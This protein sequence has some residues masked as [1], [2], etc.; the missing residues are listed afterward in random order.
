MVHI[1]FRYKNRKLYHQ[2]QSKCINF[3]D[4]QKYILNGDEVIVLD[5]G[6]GKNITAKILGSLISEIQKQNTV[7][8]TNDLHRRIVEM[9]SSSSLKMKPHESKKEILDQLS[10]APIEIEE[11]KN[12]E[13]ELVIELARLKKERVGHRGTEICCSNGMEFSSVTAAAKWAKVEW[14]EIKDC[15]VGHRFSCNDLRYWE[16]DTKGPVFLE[17]DDVEIHCSNGM[18]FQTM[19]AAAKWAGIRTPSLSKCENGK[20]HEAKN[21]LR[22][23]K[24]GME[25]SAVFFRKRRRKK[26][27]DSPSNSVVVGRPGV[28]VC[29]SNGIEYPSISAASEATNVCN[30]TISHDLRGKRRYSARGPRFWKKG[31]E[32]KAEFL[33]PVLNEFTMRIELPGLTPNTQGEA[34]AQGLKSLRKSLNMSQV[35][36]SSAVGC[37]Q[38]LISQLETGQIPYS[39]KLHTKIEDFLIKRENRTDPAN[40]QAMPRDNVDTIIGEVVSEQEAEMAEV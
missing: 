22:F 34:V 27:G 21:G 32:P 15:I 37:A 20:I 16:K 2:V 12:Q 13:F 1:I 10:P 39:E 7:F 35:Q 8:D 29:C 9:G 31:D 40:G 33:K 3:V 4:I 19:S 26:R 14:S 23:C 11:L 6:S 36:F 24:K 25:H 5:W 38:G 30:E 28:V 17:N 18:E